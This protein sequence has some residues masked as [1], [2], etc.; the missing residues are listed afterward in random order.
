MIWI[1]IMARA[2]L[3]LDDNELQMRSKLSNPT[4]VFVMKEESKVAK[5]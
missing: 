1:Y 4:I 3:I 5:T 2:V